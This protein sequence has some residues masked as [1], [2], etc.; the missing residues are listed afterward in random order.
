MIKAQKVP[1]HLRITKR[2]DEMQI[3]K[4]SHQRIKSILKNEYNILLIKEYQGYKAN[5]RKGYCERYTMVQA[6]TQQT[7]L[8][9]VTLNSLR[10]I[11]TQEGYLLHENESVVKKNEQ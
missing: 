3:L 5:R 7:I 8:R 9:G 4:Y 2:S 11:L 1:Y 10:T 6:D